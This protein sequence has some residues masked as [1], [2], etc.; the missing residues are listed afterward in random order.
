MPAAYADVPRRPPL[1]GKSG[2]AQAGHTTG[3]RVPLI[4]AGDPFNPRN[5]VHDGDFYQVGKP[6]MD[7]GKHVNFY[8]N[9]R[10]INSIR[11][12]FFGTVG[13]LRILR[14]KNRLVRGRQA[15][16]NSNV[17]I[18]APPATSYGDFATYTS[19]VIHRG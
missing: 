14:Q 8:D 10:E 7:P 15:A 12:Q 11:E 3:T 5:I 2:I 4:D 19:G 16:L 17:I 18:Q 9:T 13:K 1:P 6:F